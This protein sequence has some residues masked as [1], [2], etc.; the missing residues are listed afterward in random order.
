MKYFIYFF[1]LLSLS[2]SGCEIKSEYEKFKSFQ[3]DKNTIYLFFRETNSKNGFI[4]REYNV[5][6]SSMTHIGIGYFNNSKLKI[7]HIDNVKN[8]RKNDLI[9]STIDDFFS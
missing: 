1:L 4:S 2:I 5:N 6:N 8:N 7:L 9:I 3:Y